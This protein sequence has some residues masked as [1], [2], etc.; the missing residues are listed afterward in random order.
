MTKAVQDL[1]V[2]VERVRDAFVTALLRPDPDAAHALLTPDARLEIDPAGTA[3]TSADAVRRF[4]ADDLA[5]GLPADLTLR[6]HSRTGDRWHV[7]DEASA[8][9][10]HDREMRWL[11]PGVPATGRL[12]EVDLLTVVRVRRSR[13]T[14][15]RLVWDLLDLADQLDLDPAT[16]PRRRRALL[17]EAAPGA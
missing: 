7:V 3:I 17:R 14:R 10:T 6:R 1:M 2:E 11:L 4:L 9:F 12:V 15:V 5:H 16:L 13:V 8:T